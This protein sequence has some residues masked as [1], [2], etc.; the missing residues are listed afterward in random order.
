MKKLIIVLVALAVA[1]T[2]AFAAPRGQRDGRRGNNPGMMFRLVA[3]VRAELGLSAEQNQKLD[4]LLSEVKGKFDSLRQGMQGNRGELGEEFIA[5]DFNAEKVH[6]ERQAR[7]DAMR[8]E[9]QGYMA[10][11]F[12]Q[13]H[14][15]LT[16]EQRT[17]LIQLAEE[18]GKEMRKRMDGTRG[19][20]EGRRGF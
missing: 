5:D 9:M 1:G 17:K 10:G 20:R 11:K 12:Q 14:D 7:R 18:K 15:L 4:A 3:E 13:L 19:S 2:T 6:A 16:K 8:E